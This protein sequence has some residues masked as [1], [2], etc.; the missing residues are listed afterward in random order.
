[1]GLIDS[2]KNYQPTMPAMVWTA[3]GA[4]ALTVA[5]GFFGLGWVTGGTAQDM[6]AEAEARG[7]A[8]LAAVICEENFRAHPAALEQ[9][10]QISEMSGFR[11]RQFVEGQPWALVPG[12]DSVRRDV[13]QL[14]AARIVAMNPEDLPAQVTEEVVE[15]PEIDAG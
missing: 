2:I 9:H 11:Q 12:A 6:A 10:Q 4:S 8:E 5:A 14:C 15:T 13:A 1:M 7:Y 3:V